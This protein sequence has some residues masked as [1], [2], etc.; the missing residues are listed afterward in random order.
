MTKFMRNRAETQH[1]RGSTGK[2]K[3]TVIITVPFWSIGR[4]G[5]V[6]ANVFS[7]EEAI[8]PMS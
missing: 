7:C 6:F 3:I 2:R 4:V 5:K 8:I 1:I